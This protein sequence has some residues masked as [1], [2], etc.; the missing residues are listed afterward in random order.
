MVQRTKHRLRPSSES[1]TVS[2]PRSPAH[3]QR[4]LG[5]ELRIDRQDTLGD[6]LE[7]VG[8]AFWNNVRPVGNG[9]FAYIQGIGGGFKGAKMGANFVFEHKADGTPCWT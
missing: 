2:L 6:D 5:V 7:L 8:L 9:A 4:Y 3:L 1:Q